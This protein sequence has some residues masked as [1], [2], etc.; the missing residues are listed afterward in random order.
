MFFF[1]DFIYTFTV[2]TIYSTEQKR[3][4]QYVRHDKK[5]EKTEQNRKYDTSM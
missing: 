3:T 5:T 2:H 4:R 1:S